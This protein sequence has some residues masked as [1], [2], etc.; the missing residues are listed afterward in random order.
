MLTLSSIA[1][2]V[3][4]LHDA[5]EVSVLAYTLHP[6]AVENA[7]LDAARRGAHVR[8]RLE[9]Q[10]YNDPQGELIADNETAVRT[11]RD[12]GADAQLTNAPNSSEPALHAKAI[13]AGTTLFL[14]DRNFANDSEET[15]LRDTSPG[16]R[17]IVMDAVEGKGDSPSPLFQINK[18]DAIASES[19]LLRSAQ[20][21]DTVALETESF[22]THNRVYYALDALAK[23]GA[24]PRLLVSSLD[25]PNNTREQRAL[26]Q[27]QHDGVEIRITA[28]NEKF[29]LVD[30]RAWIGSA[31][32]TASFESPDQLDWGAR[33]DQPAI[34]S[35]LRQTFERRWQNAKPFTEA[36]T[37][38]AH[39]DR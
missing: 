26:E 28:A 30:Q 12:A 33:T 35:H 20:P 10:P 18:R 14:D 21:H 6:G 16:D 15:I 36:Q 29:A 1:A 23:A 9:G 17:A 11:L 3:S 5:R 25:V 37:T 8:V 22:G 24:R 39:S 34:V 7:L 38:S 13:V 19:Q 4:A 27:L 2:V 32:A 31:N